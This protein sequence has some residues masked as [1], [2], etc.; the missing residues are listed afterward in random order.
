MNFNTLAQKVFAVR[1]EDVPM[2]WI[3]NIIIIMLNGVRA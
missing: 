1:I 2:V 3:N